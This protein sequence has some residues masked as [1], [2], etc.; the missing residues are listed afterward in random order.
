M[1]AATV[2]GIGAGER[3]GEGAGHFGIGAGE[4]AGEGAAGDGAADGAG[5]GAGEGAGGLRADAL[6]VGAH[7]GSTPVIKNT[8]MSCFTWSGRAFS[9]SAAGSAMPR[10][11][12]PRGP[13]RCGGPLSNYILSQNRYG[14]GGGGGGEEG[15]RR[16]RKPH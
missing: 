16:R 1:G 4:R 2:T 7:A 3:A 8:A 5:D 15:R 14:G 11:R 6:D 13:P 10:A 9:A 12:G